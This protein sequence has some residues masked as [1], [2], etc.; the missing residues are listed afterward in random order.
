MFGAVRAV[1]V[2]DDLANRYGARFAPAALLRDLAATGGAF[3][4]RFANQKTA[5]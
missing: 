3:Y 2:C 1:E 4:T 5:A